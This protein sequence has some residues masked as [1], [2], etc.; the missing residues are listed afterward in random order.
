MKKWL[1]S[2]VAAACEPNGVELEGI[3]VFQGAQGLGKTLWFKRLANYD[4]GWLLEGATLNPS[5]KDSVKQA[6]SHWIVELG[7]IESTFKKSD[8][9]QLKAF[10]TKKTDELRLPYDRAFTTYQRRTAFYASVNARE[11][12]TDTS[13]NRRFWV[14]PVN[15]ID[16]NHGVDMQQLW[17]EVKETMYRPGQ[18]NW[19]L[20][21]DERAQL[22]ESNELYRT[23]S[24]V[25]DLILEHVDFKDAATKPV[26][27]TKLLR[28]LGV[29]NPR[30]ADF[31]DA[32]RI[33]SEHGKEPR[34]SSGKKIYDLSYTAI[35]DDK[36]D[37][38][39]FIAKGWD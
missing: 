30:M 11:F 2:C 34:R 27:M 33:L 26:Q 3:L 17:A 38:F 19:F 9:D 21:P 6:V 10:V 28:D 4:E 12:L 5:D 1:I 13:G 36:S 35:E 39:G 22:Q 23:Q 8:I 25:E 29:N 7:E 16:V 24:S 15:G 18:K 14:I 20:S 37:T 31:K 32:A